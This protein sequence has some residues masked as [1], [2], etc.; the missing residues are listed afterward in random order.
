M[1]I[2]D[3]QNFGF[4]PNAIQTTVPFQQPRMI[5]PNPPTISVGPQPRD[6][7]KVNGFDSARQYPM[8]PN[9]RVALFDI[10]D[11]ILYIKE[12]DASGFPTIR[13]FRFHEEIETPNSTV[14]EGKYVTVEE[15]NKFKE[16]LINGQQLVWTAESDT[17]TKSNKFG[18]SK[19]N[20]SD[21]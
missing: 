10:N 1:S 6:L 17:D 8:P 15:F 13:R 14:E 3:G 20:V 16:E 19:K 18:K 11:D 21:V 9:S 5:V 7:E 4:N 12:T 2:F